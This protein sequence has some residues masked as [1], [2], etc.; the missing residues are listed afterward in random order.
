MSGWWLRAGAAGGGGVTRAARPLPSVAWAA[1]SV[2]GVMVVLPALLLLVLLVT[3]APLW[4]HDG[5]HGNAGGSASATADSERPGA[6]RSVTNRWGAGYFPNVPLVTQH[7]QTVRFY[8]DLLRD[9]AVAINLIYTHC[10]DACPLETARLSQVRALLGDELRRSIHFYS[11]T[12]DPERDTPSVLK[13]YADKFQADPGWLFL[14]GAAAD[15]RLIAKKLGLSSLT[16]LADRDQHMPSLMVGNAATGRW[17]R[18]SAVDNPRFLAS[19]ITTFLTAGQARPGPVA[20]YSNA[21]P[22]E[23]M[24]AGRYIFRTRC[25][26]CH[27]IGQGDGVGPDLSGVTAR[28]DR[29]WLKRFIQQPDVMLAEGDPLAMELFRKYREVRMP[30]LRVGDGDVDALLQFIEE[31]GRPGPGARR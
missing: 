30:N 4:G 14:T 3:P 7:G 25:A 16:D 22:L 31:Q 10:Q 20:S 28:R 11:I 17:M 8:D 21:R 9:K 12:I 19:R 24:S 29:A 13:A 6:V 15:I 26:A 2:A 27:T 5:A 23:G 18:L 1:W